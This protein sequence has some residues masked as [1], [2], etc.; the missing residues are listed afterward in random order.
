MQVHVRDDDLVA[1]I[2]GDERVALT[3]AVAFSARPATGRCR[4]LRG[5][6]VRGGLT[7]PGPPAR[8]TRIQP[9]EELRTEYWPGFTSW[10]G[11]ATCAA[12]SHGARAPRSEAL[13]FDRQLVPD[14]CP[15]RLY[16]GAG[17]QQGTLPRPDLIP[18]SAGSGKRKPWP[19]AALEKTPDKCAPPRNRLGLEPNPTAG[20]EVVGALTV[21]VDCS[22]IELASRSGEATCAPDDCVGSYTPQ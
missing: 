3:L 21:L 10:W 4:N 11:R 5:D 19:A 13:Q 1:E 7:A 12:T 14:G 6:V 15:L 2:V 22:R 20:L 9:V 17:I 8:S 18:R 16:R